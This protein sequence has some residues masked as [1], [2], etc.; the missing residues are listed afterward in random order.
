[1]IAHLLPQNASFADK[2]AIYNEIANELY[3]WLGINHPSLNV[4]L[5]PV[6]EVKANDYNP[7]KVAPPEMKLLALSIRK[8]GVTM[9][10]VVSKS[11][12]G[13]ELVDGF[14]RKTII[15][16]KKDVMES[17]HGFV[18]ATIIDKPRE[19]RIASTVRHNQARG[20]HLVD[21]S[22]KLVVALLQSD[23][24]SAEIGKELG[25]DADEV[26]RLRQV[27]GLAEAFADKEF[28]RSWIVED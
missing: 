3:E 20:V 26:L 23:W 15:E 5:L 28:S 12:E 4:Q 24:S 9:P 11:D 17:L 27:T 10:I 8:D 13:Y 7:N 6:R 1:M 21:L 19:E 16:S 18:P 22:A 2:A 14:H 25:M